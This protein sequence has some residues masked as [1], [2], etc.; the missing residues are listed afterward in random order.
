MS[1]INERLPINVSFGSTMGVMFQTDVVEYSNGKEYVNSR[2]SQ[3]RATFDQQF[4]SQSRAEVLAIYE[5]FL[6]CRGRYHTFRVK[7]YLDFTSRLDGRSNPTA[8]DQNIGTGDGVKT[9]FQLS[10]T[11]A[12]SVIAYTKVITK[13]IEDSVLVALDGVPTTAFTINYTTGIITFIAPPASGVTVTA[14]FKF[15]Y[16]CRFNTDDIQNI[17]PILLNS[18]DGSAKDQFTIPNLSLIE[19]F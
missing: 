8:L 3:H 14:G 1:F 11:Y 2:W 13:P 6:A 17:E 4:S 5:F 9:T 15:D 16:H 19:V 10:K 12:Q 18:L 7:D